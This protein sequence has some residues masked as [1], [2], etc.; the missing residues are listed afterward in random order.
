MQLNDLHLNQ[1][2]KVKKKPHN[3][4]ILKKKA[5]KKVEKKAKNKAVKEVKKV[6]VIVTMRRMKLKMMKGKVEKKREMKEIGVRKVKV[7]KKRAMKVTVV[8]MMRVDTNDKKRKKKMMMNRKLKA[9]DSIRS[10]KVTWDP[11][12]S[13]RTNDDIAELAFYTGTIKY[14]GIVEPY[15]LNRF[16]RLLGHEQRIPFSPYSPTQAQRGKVVAS[17]V[18]K[19]GF[20][21]ELWER[22]QD[23]VLSARSKGQRAFV[24]W[25]T[26]KD[27][28][29]WKH[30]TSEDRNRRK[31]K[32]QG[33]SIR[34]ELP[35]PS[36]I[37]DNKVKKMLPN[38]G[39]LFFK[40]TIVGCTV[41]LWADK[42]KKADVEVKEKKTLTLFPD[43]GSSNVKD[44][45][46]GPHNYNATLRNMTA[47]F[48]NAVAKVDNTS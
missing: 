16:L 36:L 21:A 15:H 32:R 30:L 40:C 25:A 45:E 13:M 3:K 7:E 5:K 44:K 6:E 43:V 28:M 20:Q 19:Y 38:K 35:P 26:N 1:L 41:F 48:E 4:N 33:R 37:D 29:G 14:F 24:T 31:K 9:L 39:R 8:M 10:N 47:M 12:S 23:H 17:Y 34:E 18:V 22:W 2:R 11:Y 27:Y 46:V 42:A